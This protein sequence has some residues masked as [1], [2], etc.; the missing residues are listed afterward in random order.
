MTDRSMAARANLFAILHRTANFSRSFLM[1]PRLVFLALLWR[2][3]CVP[4]IAADVAIS[5]PSGIEHSPVTIALTGSPGTNI[6]FSRDGGEPSAKSELYST[7][8]TLSHT[9]VIRAAAFE[10]SGVSAI[11]TRTYIFPEDVIHQDG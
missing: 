1:K 9:V 7:L 8:I 5:R 3:A 4:L 2:V 11:S 10:S 6:R